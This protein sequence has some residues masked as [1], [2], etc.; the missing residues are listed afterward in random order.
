MLRKIYISMNLITGKAGT[1]RGWIRN[2]SVT[3]AAGDQVSIHFYKLVWVWAQSTPVCASV[4]SSVKCQPIRGHLHSVMGENPGDSWEELRVGP[5]TEDSS[6]CMS[7][8]T[9]QN[10]SKSSGFV[11]LYFGYIVTFTKVLTIHHSPIH[12]S[13]SFSFI[14]P[15]LIPEYFQQVSFFNLYT[16][17]E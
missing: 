7:Y 4:S 16:W 6:V 14:P 11:L 17:K 8:F 13:P 2:S 12:P 9:W 5:C 10:R 15:S 3:Q 1:L